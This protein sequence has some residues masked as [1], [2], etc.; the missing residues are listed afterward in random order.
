MKAELLNFRFAFI[1]NA[2]FR[3]II[4]VQFVMS[5]LVVCF[6]LYQLTKTTS[7]AKYIEMTLYMSCM[8]T[9]IFFYCWYGNEV[10]LKVSHFYS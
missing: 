3:L 5:L 1:I 2:K 6:S 9:Q 4:T 7:H 8:L 10:K